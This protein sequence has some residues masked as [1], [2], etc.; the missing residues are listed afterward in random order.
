M[1]L[2][3]YY[4]YSVQNK[5]LPVLSEFLRRGIKPCILRKMEFLPTELPD[6]HLRKVIGEA[7]M[8][9]HPVITGNRDQSAVESTV[10][11]G[12]GLSQRIVIEFF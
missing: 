3:V 1:C 8:H 10:K 2:C 9:H 5:P 11:G 4:F 6:A 7:V 12:R